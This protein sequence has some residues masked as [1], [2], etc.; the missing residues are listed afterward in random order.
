MERKL[1]FYTNPQSRGRIVRWLLEEAE[2]T[3]DVELVTFGKMMN[4]ADYRQLN[5]M[6]KVPSLRHGSTVVTETAAICAYVADAF[7]ESQ[8]APAL[9]D[10]GD[11][12]RWLFFAAGPLEHAITN[13]NLGFEVPREKEA[14]VGYGNFAKTIDTLSVAVQTNPYIAGSQFSAADIYVGS[15]IGYGMQFKT[16]PE[17]PEFVAYWQKLQT[18]PAFKRAAELDDELLP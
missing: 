15:H 5:P 6:T 18:R 3:Y 14:T 12:Y 17:R 11:Y 9:P 4:S 8:L 13:R 16:I 7:P 1:T 10:R 2:L